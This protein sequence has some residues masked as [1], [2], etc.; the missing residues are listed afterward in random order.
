MGVSGTYPSDP[1]APPLP[2]RRNASA[3]S[4]KPDAP[5]QMEPAEL[6]KG[7]HVLGLAYHNTGFL[8]QICRRRPS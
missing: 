5:N 1:N 7:Y 3:A 6:G 8:T 4:T 2:A